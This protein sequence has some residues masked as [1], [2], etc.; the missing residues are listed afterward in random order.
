MKA[1]QWAA[2][3]IVLA[4]ATP[5]TIL[6]L[7]P[8]A[9]EKGEEPRQCA[10]S[11][12]LR[13]DVAGLPAGV[14]VAADETL[15]MQ[16]PAAVSATLYAVATS[17]KVG[18]SVV[19]LLVY[20]DGKGPI[21]Q[22]T[23]EVGS[24]SGTAGPGGIHGAYLNRNGR[25]VAVALSRDLSGDDLTLALRDAHYPSDGLASLGPLQVR[26]VLATSAPSDIPGLGALTISPGRYGAVVSFN[27]DGTR[28]PDSNQRAVAVAQ[29]CA[30]EGDRNRKAFLAWWFGVP[31][32]SSPGDPGPVHF[33]YPAPTGE[34]IVMAWIWERQGI[35]TYLA[36]FGLSPGE[37][38]RVFRS[39]RSQLS[40]P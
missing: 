39:S 31:E 35:V 40:V 1:R 11:R 32:A 15:P 6:V 5:A 16:L 17:P 8:T 34:G 25:P 29:Y 3:A 23:D 27:D 18:E 13:N 14:R 26:S 21:M 12:P 20:Q 30:T 7:W 9:A 38:E 10:P 4:L 22:P 2:A 37:S 24:V 19:A 36:T 33:E 28:S